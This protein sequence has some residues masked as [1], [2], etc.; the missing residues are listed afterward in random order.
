MQA[1][2]IIASCTDRKRL[3]VPADL[4]LRCLPIKN[5][6]DRT[7]QWWGRISRHHSPTLPALDLYSGDH[8]AVIK[9]LPK[10]AVGAGFRSCLWAASA[11]YGLVPASALLRS[12]SATF[13]SGH[14]DSVAGNGARNP[15]LTRLWWTRLSDMPGPIK[16]VPRTVADIVRNNPRAYVLIVA[17]ASYIA[18]ME[19]DL[20]A[21][22]QES[23]HPNR[24]LIVS[25]R[26]RFAS[27]PLEAHLI[28]SEA[29]LQSRLGGARS[30]LHAR[31]AKKIL[32]ESRDWELSAELLKARYQRLVAR[33]HELPRFDRC[34]MTD[35][36]V[37]QFIRAETGRLPG[38][39]CARLLR[40]LRDGGRACEQSRFKSL[41]SQVRKIAHA[42]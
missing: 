34:R 33:C 38:V 6:P 42:C 10:I 41:F 20:L 28:P 36:E 24:L 32:E 27:S 2:H 23:R 29:R 16:G 19:D 1:I 39:S 9:T 11:G 7:R 14:P 17:S 15:Q 3:P 35:E 13:A 30:S 22:L 25:T 5:A 40:V 12:Y 26:G 8:W 31:V 21:A 37:R 18:A 4:R